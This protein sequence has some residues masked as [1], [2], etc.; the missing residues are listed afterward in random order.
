MKEVTGN[1][2]KKL[3]RIGAHGGGVLPHPTHNDYAAPYGARY[4]CSGQAISDRQIGSFTV[5]FTSKAVGDK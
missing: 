5:G 1:S 4:S 3:D 2:N